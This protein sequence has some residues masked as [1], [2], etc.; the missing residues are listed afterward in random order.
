MSANLFKNLEL[1]SKKSALLGQR[2][3]EVP[4]S[5]IKTAA[6]KDGGVC[7]VKQQ[8]DNSYL[9]LTS[10]TPI[11]DA[12]N[13]IAKI[14]DRISSGISPIVVIG[15]NPGYT[16]DITYKH[17]NEQYHQNFIPRRIYVIINSLECLYGWL[18][19][20]DRSSILEN[21]YIEF[22][23]TDEVSKIVD[24]CKDDEQ[25]SHLFT[26]VSSLSEN[27]AMQ[28]IEPLAT[29]FIE[30]QEEEL[31]LHKENCKY[32]EKQTDEEL[33]IIL[34]GEGNRKPRML[35]PSHASSTVV[36]YSVRDTKAMFEKEGWDVEIIYMKTDLSKWRTAKRINEFKPDVYML[37]NHLRTEEDDF[38]PPDMMFITWVQDTVSYINNSQN[39]KLWN[40]HVQSKSKRRDLIIGYVG[41]IK[42]YGYLEERLEECPMIVNEDIFKARELT[43]ED[44]EKYECNICFASNR[45]KE[46]SLII[47]EDLIPKLA[48][49]GF[50]I[51]L[52]K[53]IHDHLW[54]HYRSEGTCTTYADL[55][56]KIRE[57]ETVNSLL[58]SLHDQNDFDYIIQRL[59]WELNDVIYRHI[60]L[61]WIVQ[62]SDIKLHLYGRGW[63]NHPVFSPFARGALN[64]KEEL[65]TAYQFADFC[66]HLNSMEGDH[67]RVQEIFASQS[68]VLSRSSM[69]SIEDDCRDHI[70]ATK[71]L[72]HFLKCREQPLHNTKLKSILNLFTD[73]PGSCL[74][75]FYRHNIL[76]FISQSRSKKFYKKKS[77]IELINKKEIARKEKLS[78][79]LIVT[80]VF[81]KTFS[82]FILSKTPI[83]QNHN[84]VKGQFDLINFLL[85]IK[86]GDP[87]CLKELDNLKTQTLG[88]L[89]TPLLYLV[90]PELFSQDT[91]AINKLSI[92]G[93]LNLGVNQLSKHRI[94]D[95]TI[96]LD[97]CT[98]QIEKLPNSS[99]E[100]LIYKLLQAEKIETAQNLL[101]NRDFN[102]RHLYLADIASQNF[103]KA[104]SKLKKL[105]TPWAVFWQ[106]YCHYRLNDISTARELCFNLRKS[107][108]MSPSSEI[109]L[110]TI[111]RSE[112]KIK[113]AIDFFEEALA[114]T[115][116][117]ENI[118]EICFQLSITF[119][120]IENTEKALFYINKGLKGDTWKNNPCTPLNAL[121][122][123]FT[124]H[125]KVNSLKLFL[126]AY[127]S[128][129]MWPKSWMSLQGYLLSQ[130]NNNSEDQ[131]IFLHSLKNS[132]FLQN[133]LRQKLSLDDNPEQ[134]KQKVKKAMFPFHNEE[135]FERAFDI[136]TNPRP[137]HA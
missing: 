12:Q 132:C 133:N 95:A 88:S 53:Q 44:K 87:N 29:F 60:V 121:L 57:I 98:D 32:Y 108:A 39:A 54:C 47:K 30:R 129:W 94:K 13:A 64:C 117:T 14:E 114:N 9:P 46:T 99:Q 86:K 20:E 115:D 10:S 51:E 72:I 33:D 89:L 35:I 111:F 123:Q 112:Q 122:N 1:L 3:C 38:Y 18:K 48:R 79:S 28:I 43:E 61:E 124:Y 8:K 84:S 76:P 106:A 104:I 25:R 136:N 42:E 16:L 7:F 82:Y 96:C 102:L 2:I 126:D 15:L 90:K 100:I 19:L 135:S 130:K 50:S 27:K 75:D 23:H 91:T 131:K 4:S 85:H 67:Q 107:K 34:S 103:E 36:Q 92:K 59:F 77:L 127:T 11:S 66:L 68:Q 55:E 41:Q 80:D 125:E 22:Y 83:P 65:S 69:Q 101:V 120:S 74:A 73:Y 118:G 49:Y 31:K 24:L 40:E 58:N 110:G 17:V 56:I 116:H 109:L 97:A 5:S 113:Q 71:N 134:F 81:Y 128:P 137:L 93:K 26:P 119:L 62:S 6:T 21:E 52:L 37:V 105:E 78:E 45:S 63:D 70:E